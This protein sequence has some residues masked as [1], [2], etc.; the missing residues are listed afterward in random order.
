MTIFIDDKQKRVHR[1]PLISGLSVDEFL[2]NNANPI[3]LHQNEM[4]EYMPPGEVPI[5][6]SWECD[7]LGSLETLIEPHDQNA[8]NDAD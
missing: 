7:D 5:L 4:W 2:A 3:W 8:G 6:N 1:P